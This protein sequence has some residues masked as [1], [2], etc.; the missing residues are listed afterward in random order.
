MSSPLVWFVGNRDPAITENIVDEAGVA[1]D[2]TGKTVQFRA[3][4]IGASALLVDQPATIV[5]PPGVDGQVLYAW[6]TADI[7]ANGILA[8]PRRALVWWRVT[9][10]ASGKT[11]DVMEAVIEV[12][13]HAPGPLTYVELEE[14]KS[15]IE[16]SGQS[17]ADGDLQDAL[18][19]ASR[20][21]DGI[22]HRRFYPD[23]DAAQ[24]R[25]YSPRHSGWQEI[26]DLITLTS[27]ASDYDGDGTFE[28]TWVENTDFTLE[29]LNSVAN[30]RPFE[31]LCRHPRSSFCFSPYPRS[32]KVTGKFGWAAIP[33]EVVKATKIRTVQLMLRARQA[34]FGVLGVGTEGAIHISR[35]DPDIQ[36]L[37]SDVTRIQVLA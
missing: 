36:L 34:P 5:T 24:V 13:A 2:L 18:L 17:F 1:V 33:P 19:A 23:A 31:R 8:D 7:A 30:A 3:R 4:E 12:R 28:Q 16:L 21:V 25:Y 10:T 27:V 35:Y 11:E 26:D 22:C 32:L 14:I 9:T 15:S 37:L 29:P 6:S 20:D